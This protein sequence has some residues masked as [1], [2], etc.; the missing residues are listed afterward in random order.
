MVLSHC[1]AHIYSPDSGTFFE[2]VQAVPWTGIKLSL[3]AVSKMDPEQSSELPASLPPDDNI[4]DA[5]AF[6]NN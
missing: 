6:P 5:K 3:T 1:R 2:E 4:L